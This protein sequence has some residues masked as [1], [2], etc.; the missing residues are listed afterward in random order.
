V[1]EKIKLA[2]KPYHRETRISSDWKLL[3]AF[4]ASLIIVIIIGLIGIFQ[5]QFLFTKVDILGSRYLP[6]Q[7]ATLELKVSNNLYAMGIRNYAFWKSSRYLEAARAAADLEAV[8]QAAAEF[9]SQLEIYNL[10]LDAI[11]KESGENPSWISKQRQWIAEIYSYEKELREL[12]SRIIKLIEGKASFEVVNMSIMSFES[13]LYRI[14]DFI[15]ETIQKEII[16]SVQEQLVIA[17]QTRRRAI[18][19]LWWSLIMGVLIGAETAWLVYKNLKQESKRRQN[20][21]LEMIR[22]EERERQH[23]SAQVHDQMSQDLSALRIY[24]GLIQQQTENPTDELKEQIIQGK[25][26]V[27]GLI[28]KSHNISLLLRPPSLDEIGLVESLEALMVDYSRLSKSNYEYEKPMQDIRLSPEYSLYLYRLTQE[29]LTNA[30]KYAK[31]KNVKISLKADKKTV[32]LLY[33]DDGVGFDYDSLAAQPRPSSV[34]RLKLGLLGLK[35]RAELL[36]GSM[37]IDTSPGHGTRIHV[38][39]HLLQ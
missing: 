39:L 20:I 22:T 1:A 26:I 36:G 15:S 37:N 21:V 5:I 11:E 12:G 3:G 28:E 33:E 10:H 6:M 13:S 9:D 23:L 38:C 34:D 2:L 35:E 32:E 30:A 16:N 25:K 27:T 31:A 24:L 14:D 19:F 4:S 18:T 8:E 7:V 29:A 17:D